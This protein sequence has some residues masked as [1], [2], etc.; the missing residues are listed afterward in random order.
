MNVHHRIHVPQKIKTIYHTKIVKVPE[1]HHYFHEKEKIIQVEAPKKEHPIY[2]PLKEEDV[3]DFSALDH[4]DH[5][6]G[7]S[8][9]SVQKKRAP[10]TRP[11][12]PIKRK[13]VVVLALVLALA[14]AAPG[15]GH[16]K[17]EHV[18]IHVPY[19]VHTV[20][21]HHVEKVHVPVPII[22]KV[23]IHEPVYH[24]P[25]HHHAPIIEHGGW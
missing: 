9:Q 21:H 23:Y 8:R 17:H 5:Y 2:P 13:V 22:K 24:E 1:H 25:I 15:W 7:E 11:R 16:S 6:F 4:N 3:G 14:S 19:Q 10:T 20:H 12:K 18:R